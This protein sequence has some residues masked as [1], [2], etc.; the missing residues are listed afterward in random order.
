MVRHIVIRVD[1]KKFKKYSEL[2]E[3]HGMTWEDLLDVA[4]RLSK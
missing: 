1:D 2:K 4:F 3:R